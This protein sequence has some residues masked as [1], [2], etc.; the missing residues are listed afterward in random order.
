MATTV[1]ARQD[2]ARAL[3]QEWAKTMPE[4]HTVKKE[5]V[6][7][8]LQEL[9]RGL[10]A[11]GWHLPAGEVTCWESWGLWA[12]TETGEKYHTGYAVELVAYYSFTAQAQYYILAQSCEGQMHIREIVCARQ[13][14]F[15]V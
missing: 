13:P 3:A 1:K 10:A 4:P 14:R 2:R 11:E 15:E 5:G 7:A 8:G 9:V 12:T 6:Y